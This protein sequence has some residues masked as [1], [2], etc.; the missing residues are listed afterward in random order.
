MHRDLKASNVFLKGSL[1]LPLTDLEL[2]LGDLGAA[3]LGSRATTPVQTPHF[4]AP[5]VAKMQGDYGQ[6]ADVWGFGC[7]LFQMLEMGLPHGEE[8]K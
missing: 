4:M 5:E 2:K 3:K 1:E 6:E 8:P 7:L